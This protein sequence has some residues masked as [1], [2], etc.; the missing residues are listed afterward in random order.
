MFYLAALMAMTGGFACLL[1]VSEMI[2]NILVYINEKSK[3][4]SKRNGRN[5]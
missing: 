3:K 4:R 5:Y 2:Y 1:W